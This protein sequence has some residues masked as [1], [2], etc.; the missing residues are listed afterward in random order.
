MKNLLMTVLAVLTAA[1]TLSAQ[2]TLRFESYTT[3]DVC[4]NERR[5]LLAVNLGKVLPSDSLV[6]FDITIGYDRTKLRPTDVLKEGT[7]SLSMAYDPFLNTVVPNEMRIAAGNII[8]TVHGD[9]PL[10]AVTG[11]F[12]GTCVDF[13]TLGYPWPATFNEEFKRKYTVIRRDTVKAIAVAKGNKNSGLQA[14]DTVVSLPSDRDYVD[15]RVRGVALKSDSTRYRFMIKCSRE[16]LSVANDKPAIGMTDIVANRTKDGMEI[17][18][19]VTSAAPEMVLRYTHGSSTRPDSATVTISSEDLSLCSC[20]KPALRDTMRIAIDPTVSVASSDEHV[21]MIYLIDNAINIQCDHEEMK[22]AQI[23][24]ITGELITSATMQRDETVLR[25]LN[26][27][28]GSYVLRVTCGNHQHV[29]MIL[30]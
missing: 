9:L 26:L 11:D 21:E 5:W 2:D 23:F 22:N 6:S 19:T 7:L 25:P 17:T 29:K 3:V 10:V 1:S 12:L 18:A 28:A 24:S 4:S 20:E 14:V 16:Q 27:T 15:V 8:R 30:K 13:D